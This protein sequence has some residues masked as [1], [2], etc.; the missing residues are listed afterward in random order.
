MFVAKQ[1]RHIITKLF[2]TE[3]YLKF[4]NLENKAICCPRFNWMIHL[5]QFHSH[6]T[7]FSNRPDFR[8]NEDSMKW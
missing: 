5:R 8:Y 4:F 3:V 1:K 7:S 6:W 2:T